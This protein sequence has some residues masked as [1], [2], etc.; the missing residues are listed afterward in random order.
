[1]WNVTSA[2]M[3]HTNGKAQVPVY[4][5]AVKMAKFASRSGTTKAPGMA[6]LGVILA[7]H[8]RWCPL[9]GMPW[10]VSLVGGQR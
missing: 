1:M 10:L 6:S 4:L 9:A 7:H 3:G 8:V 5:A 2:E